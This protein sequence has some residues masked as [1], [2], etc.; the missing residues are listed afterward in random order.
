ME[1]KDY[2][3]VL[4]VSPNATEDEI[5]R[6]YRKLARETHPDLQGGPDAEAKFKEINEAHDVLKSPETRAEYDMI[7]SGGS[8][9][10]TNR[11]GRADT[12]GRGQ[13][14][15]GGFEFQRGNPEAEARFG[16]FFNSVFGR[17]DRFSHAGPVGGTPNTA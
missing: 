2:Y 13:Y 16:D 14:W 15:D 5:K 3:A 17:G 6:A 8:G 9:F 10:G 12:T 1:F 7:R 4:G 11:T